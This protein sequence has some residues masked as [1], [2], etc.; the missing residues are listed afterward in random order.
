MWPPHSR[1]RAGRCGG[2]CAVAPTVTIL[3]FEDDALDVRAAVRS[4]APCFQAQKFI[5]KP[6]IF[7]IRARRRAAGRL[8]WV[9]PSTRSGD[10][11]FT[12]QVS[13]TLLGCPRTVVD[14]LLS[15]GSDERRS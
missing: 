9:A 15:V 6:T 13:R 5:G 10:D 7:L 8:E 3:T 1:T 11:S 2:M 12:F 4:A 14:G